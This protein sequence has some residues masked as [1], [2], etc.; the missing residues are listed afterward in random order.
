MRHYMAPISTPGTMC[1]K[2]LANLAPNRIKMKVLP[3]V[4]VTL[5]DNKRWNKIV[6]NQIKFIEVVKEWNA[7]MCDGKCLDWPYQEHICTLH[8]ALVIRGVLTT[9]GGLVVVSLSGKRRR[10]GDETILLSNDRFRTVPP[11]HSGVRCNCGC[12]K[13]HCPFRSQFLC[14]LEEA[15]VNI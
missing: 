14:Y 1:G 13:L 7:W 9:T 11:T 6:K 12:P 4:E 8:I 3:Q 10:S 5:V 2:V 15:Y